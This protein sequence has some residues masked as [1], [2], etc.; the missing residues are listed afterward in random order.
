MNE[1]RVKMKKTTYDSLELRWDSTNLKTDH[2]YD[3]RGTCEMQSNFTGFV[4]LK[5]LIVANL[6]YTR[7]LI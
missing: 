6:I 5:I 4:R 3:W 1:I 7:F 2:N